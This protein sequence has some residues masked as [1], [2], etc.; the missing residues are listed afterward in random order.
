M[1]GGT[2]SPSV[3]TAGQTSMMMMSSSMQDHHIGVGGMNPNLMIGDY[4]PEPP[5]K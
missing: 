1:I 3:M 4:V 5:F 2:I